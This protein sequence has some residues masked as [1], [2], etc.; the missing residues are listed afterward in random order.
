M[1]LIL[2][3]IA[4]RRGDRIAVLFVAVLVEVLPFTFCCAHWPMGLLSLHNN[5][6]FNFARGRLAQ[7][8]FE[9]L[10]FVQDPQR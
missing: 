4:G 6:S 9:A 7:M 5:F 8:A 10:L 1:S 2:V 3:S